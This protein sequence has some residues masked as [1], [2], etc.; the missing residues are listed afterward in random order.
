MEVSNHILGGNQKDSH[1]INVNYG[2]DYTADMVK[3]IRL[4][5]AGEDCPRSNGKLH[6]A[7][8]IECGHIFKLGDKYSKALGAS[9]LDEKGESKI[10]LM[11]CYG[12]GVGRTMAA[13]IEQNYDEYGIIWPTALAPYLVDVIPANIKNAEQMQLA[14]KIYEQLNAEHLDAMLD[15]RDERPGF[16]FK[17]ADLIGFPF[18]VICGKKTAEN[19]VELKIRKTGETF[20]ISADEIISKIKD[21]E[22]QY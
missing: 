6:S 13:A 14:E 21:L 18:K 10:M 9:Y 2:R 19:I 17:D 5:K 12:I 15:D 11:G 3:D 20:E 4:V 7:R 1:Y 16:K 8:G 22:K